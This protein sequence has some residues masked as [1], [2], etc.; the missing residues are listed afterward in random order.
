[1][2]VNVKWS[3]LP[4]LISGAGKYFYFDGNTTIGDIRLRGGGTVKYLSGTITHSGDF[5]MFNGN[6]SLDITSIQIDRFYQRSNGT[7]ITLINDLNCN[8]LQYSPSSNINFNV[9]GAY[10]INC[11][12]FITNGNTTVKTNDST[13]NVSKSLYLRGALD[14][15]SG[16]G[17]FTLNLLPGATQDVSASLNL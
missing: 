14:R 3:V 15:I 12:N 16:G 11:K 10:S 1:M 13:I 7:T 5:Q 17:T 4:T 6:L 2:P 9:S 8:T